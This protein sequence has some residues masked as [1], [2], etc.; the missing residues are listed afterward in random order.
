MKAVHRHKGGTVFHTH[1]IGFR[2]EFQPVAHRAQ[3][4]SWQVRTAS[5]ER[6]RQNT[7]KHGAQPFE[8]ARC[9]N[10][11]TLPNVHVAHSAGTAHNYYRKDCRFVMTS[12]WSGEDRTVEE[13]TILKRSREVEEACNLWWRRDGSTSRRCSCA[14]LEPERGEAETLACARSPR[15]MPATRSAMARSGPVSS[16]HRL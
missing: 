16:R 12:V 9:L 4:R 5:N 14:P 10:P 2:G 11:P 13:S 8:L 3:A 6:T 15:T 7:G 1:L